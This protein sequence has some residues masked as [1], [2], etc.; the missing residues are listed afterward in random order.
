MRTKSRDHSNA[1]VSSQKSLRGAYKNPTLNNDNTVES[2]DIA[3]PAVSHTFSNN[4]SLSKRPSTKKTS[5]IRLSTSIHVLT[6]SQ[7]Q[8][9]RRSQ[10]PSAVNAVA[11]EELQQRQ[12][13]AHDPAAVGLA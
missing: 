6:F 5:R 10:K 12:E 9:R 4:P 3:D 11:Q 8:N 2:F 13:T 1:A 7:L